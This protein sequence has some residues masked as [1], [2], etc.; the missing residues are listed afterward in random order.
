M[1]IESRAMYVW[2]FVFRCPTTSLKLVGSMNAPPVLY[3]LFR[4]D[5]AAVGTGLVVP[6]DCPVCR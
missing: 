6:F 5:T 4:T 1:G 2:L 3:V